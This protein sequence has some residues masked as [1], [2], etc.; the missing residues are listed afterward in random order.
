MGGMKNMRDLERK[1]IAI[2]T[3]VGDNYGNRLQNYALQKALQKFGAEVETLNNPFEPDYREYRCR[4]KRILRYIVFG[5]LNNKSKFAQVKRELNFEKFNRRYIIF[6]DFWT[7]KP[8]DLQKMNL[9]YDAFVCGSDQVWNSEAKQ[10]DGRWFADFAAKTKRNSYAASFGLDY[11]Y[12]DRKDEFKKYLEGMNRISVREESGVEIVKTI[13]GR[14]AVR[15]IDPTLL[16]TQEE[17]D[18]IVQVPSVDLPPKYIVTYFLGE[19]TKEVWGI[20]EKVR[21]EIGAEVVMLNCISNPEI[22]A[23]SPSEFLYV[24]KNAKMVITDSFHGTVFSIIYHVPFWVCNRIGTD[25]AM[26]TRLDSLLTLFCLNDRK[27]TSESL[28]SEIMKID[29]TSVDQIIQT[30][31]KKSYD[32]LKIIVGNYEK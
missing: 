29:F 31:R 24:I 8:S 3:M 21:D 2:L 23:F 25:K 12:E 19:I 27:R 15:H 26:M 16:L 30:E 22:F 18:G 17:W 32:Y 20:V 13:A 7:N 6:S 4:L 5:L 1:K 9:Y 14:Q 11:I 28:V 10:I